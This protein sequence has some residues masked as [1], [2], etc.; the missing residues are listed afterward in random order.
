[1]A[2]IGTGR[3]PVAFGELLRR[4]RAAAGLSQEALAARSGISADAISLLERGARTTARTST[5]IRL[6]DALRLRSPERD[7]FVAAALPDRSGSPHTRRSTMPRELPRPPADFTGRLDE[8]GVLRD[9]LTG[10][11][12][13]AV[14]G[15]IHGMGGIGK[16][17]LGIVA[18]HESAEA[19]VFPDGQLYVN[20]QGSTPGLPP[21]DPLEALGR[22][23]RSLGMDSDAI[24]V[25][26]HEAAA[27]FR[28]L[29]AKRRLL[30]LLDDACDAEQIRPL[31]PG[32]P[33]CVVLITSRQVL[34]T[35]E[36]SPSMHLGALPMDQAMELLGRLAGEERVVA[37]PRA[38]AEVVRLCGGLPLAIRIAGARLAA[39]PGWPV[40]ELAAHLTDAGRRLGE[41]EVGRLAVRASFDVSLRAL[42]A[43]PAAVDRD[44]AAS[45]GLLSLLEGPDL[46]VAVAACLLDEPEPA[47]RVV[48]ERL[49]DAHLLESPQPRRYRFHD[50]VRLHARERAEGLY[51]GPVQTA[52][53]V[54]AFGFYVATAWTT[55]SLLRPGDWRLLT[56][57]PRW[58]D[59]GL[60]F[61]DAAAAR[62]WLQVERPNLLAAVAQM[63]APAGPTSAAP[64]ELLG[65]LA[66]ALVGFFFTGRSHWREWERVTRTVLEVASRRGARLGRAM[67]QNDLG[68][69]HRT[70]ARYS[71]AVACH[72]DSLG[73]F[74]ETGNRHGECAALGNLG[75][76]YGFMGRYAEALTYQ[77][78]SLA[79]AREL[80]DRSQ[81]AAGSTTMGM[82]NA[83]LGRHAEAVRHQR[84]SLRIYR[85]LV[86]RRG[87]ALSL[88]NLGKLLEETGRHVEAIRCLQQCLEISRDL[89]H[90]RVE[91]NA[92]N[93]L[94]TLY[95]RTGR[96][97]DAV[98]CQ[99]RSRDIADELGDPRIRAEA[100]R[101]L[102]AAYRT[103]GR[104][105]EA[106]AV[107]QEALAIFDDMQAPQ[108]DVIRARLASLAG[109]S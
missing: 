23:L 40:R 46:S 80:G 6:A 4:Y 108:A 62:E 57:D 83:W 12:G 47:T 19:G 16:S 63:A 51:A 87:E 64:P 68:L 9:L 38:T 41:L 95:E 61:D 28:S 109:N 56:V 55:M 106:K 15:A 24:P 2:D 14:I 81:E 8:L 54:R 10:G 86:D 91:A 18:A 104:N 48:L 107:W 88:N 34:G 27:R 76:T 96:C 105:R 69:V 94:G 82:V 52:A 93:T 98:E 29:T 32:S 97:A 21:L 90:R 71:E 39:R 53:L 45:F 30:V 103:L 92:L 100:L 79:I 3:R 36:G 67:A 70:Q 1:M 25:E 60:V 72:E 37:E 59:G 74:R 11:R 77:G 7:E 84:E 99:T 102:G 26:L 33:A 78:Q 75:M 20:L 85:E 22:M 42:Q 13:P 44:A 66:S 65:Q 5:V 58:S 17:A 35:L 73:V 31:L 49:V 50:L 43:S 101:D 89:G